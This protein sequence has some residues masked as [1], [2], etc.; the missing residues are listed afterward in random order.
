MMNSL[1]IIIF[2]C[3]SIFIVKNAMQ[4][5]VVASTRHSVFKERV[6]NDKWEEKSWK[7]VAERR[8]SERH[9][10]W[11]G[12]ESAGRRE[13]AFED[14]M[15]PEETV[16]PLARGLSSATFLFSHSTFRLLELKNPKKKKRETRVWFKPF[17]SFCKKKR[18]EKGKF[19]GKNI[20]KTIFLIEIEI[21]I[22]DNIGN[23][24]RGS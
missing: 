15:G 20:E 14:E 4:T 19:N 11:Q 23:N 22:I 2:E 12:E 7:S 1:C 16:N 9:V 5:N 21:K 24:P 18:N 3:D 13:N 10:D 17:F 8:K 6:L